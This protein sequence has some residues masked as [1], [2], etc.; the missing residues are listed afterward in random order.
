MSIA[1]ENA[2]SPNGSPGAAWNGAAAAWD[3]HAPKIWDRLRSAT[4]AMLEMT[5]I[6]PGQQVLDIAADAGDRTLDLARRVGP[7]G[8][9]IATD[10]C[11]LGLKFLS[12]TLAGLAAIRSI[13][14][15]GARF[16]S[17]VFAGPDRNPCLRILMS[18]AMRHAG[19]S[20]RDPF[21]PGGLLSLGRQG[22]LDGRFRRA[23]FTNVA[24]T[25]LDAPF[26]LPR[27]ADYLAFVRD[28]AAPIV[29][30]L[31]LLPSTA[32]AAAGA[33]IETQ[34]DACQATRGWVGP[35]AL[36]LT[37]GQNVA[38]PHGAAGQSSAVRAS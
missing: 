8:C 19:P 9:D 6:R 22:D 16:C 10:T 1:T 30:L 32:R 18:T 7:L 29:Q 13:L 17:V 34:L 4:D 26:R 37:V 27:T 38:S 14:K 31:A 12:D 21:V 15:P 11:R 25:R 35:N 33:D 3:R 5:G 23:G 20:A 36:V 2:T 24:T 28:A